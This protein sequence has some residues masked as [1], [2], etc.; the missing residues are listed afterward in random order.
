M[1]SIVFKISLFTIHCSLLVIILCSCSGY[2]VIPVTGVTKNN[3]PK[4][5]GYYYSLPQTGIKVDVT[6]RQSNLTKGPYSDYAEKYLGLTNIIRKDKVSYEI[7][8]VRI[9]SFT[10]KDPDHFYF[11]RN[12]SC[13]WKK[14]PLLV[15]FNENGM[16]NSINFPTDRDLTV[17]KKRDEHKGMSRYN[18]EYNLIISPNLNEK[19]DT[20]IE[21]FHTD[22]ISIEKKTIKKIY[23]EKSSEEK[24]KEA[25]AFLL[26]IRDSRHNVITGNAE[27][28][29][30]KDAI[31]YM[32]DQLDAEERSYISLFT[33]DTSCTVVRYSFTYIPKK[34]EA[35]SESALFFFSAQEGISM[36]SSQGSEVITISIEKKN[37]LSSLEKFQSLLDTA[38]SKRK[39]FY[40]RIPETA[41]I[42]V[43]KGKASLAE[44]ELP[45]CQFGVISQLPRSTKKILFNPDYGNIRI[46]K[47]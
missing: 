7:A 9:S 39:G 5:T 34:P 25:A 27:V 8:D 28:P 3:I 29:Y 16:L 36:N 37:A 12:I 40:Y 20:V 18:N 44:D 4:K 11:V 41:K 45:V 31:K 38:S 2:R 42:S 30:S 10:H 46:I 15:S 47:E 33:G 43:H 1:K 17:M 23:T 13:L 24:A 32:K 14:N 22:T 21:H 35:L 26:K 6:V 19:V